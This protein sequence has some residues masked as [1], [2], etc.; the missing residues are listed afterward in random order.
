[1]LEWQK[2]KVSAETLQFTIVACTRL[3]AAAAETT[4]SFGVHVYVADRLKCN[5]SK[6]GESY[7][8]QRRVGFMRR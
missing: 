7:Y 5:K 4:R 8:T 2:K 1:M 6:T 3:S